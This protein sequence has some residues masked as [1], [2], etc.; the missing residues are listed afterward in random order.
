MKDPDGSPRGRPC[1]YALY[2]EPGAIYWYERKADNGCYAFDINYFTFGFESYNTTRVWS[3][4]NS[5]YPT[6]Y[7]PQSDI[8]LLRRVYD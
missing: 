8:C 7:V 3:A 1:L 2:R 4:G 5:P 6:Q